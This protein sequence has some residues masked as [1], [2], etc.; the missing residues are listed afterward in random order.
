MELALNLVWLITAVGSYA[1]LARRLA[2]ESG[3]DI[4][5]I[6]T[7]DEWRRGAGGRPRHIRQYCE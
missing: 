6:G 7:D 2:K 3:I 1:L 4:I 5:A